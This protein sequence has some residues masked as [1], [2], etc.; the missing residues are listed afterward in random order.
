MHE[1]LPHLFIRAITGKTSDADLRLLAWLADP[2][3][4]RKVFGQPL[5][6]VIGY[7]GPDFR[8]LLTVA[9]QP[10]QNTAPTQPGS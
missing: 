8:A 6:E 2:D 3:V 1:L 9:E 5:S 7:Y 4:N 10:K